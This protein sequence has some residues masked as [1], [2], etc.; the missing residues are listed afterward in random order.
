M[1]ARCR[2]QREQP[3]LGLFQQARIGIGLGGQL[4]EKGFRLGQRLLRAFQGDQRRRRRIGCIGLS[5]RDQALQRTRSS[6]QRRRRAMAPP[7]VRRQFGKCRGNRLRAPLALL[8]P[9]PLLRQPLLLALPR[10]QA[11]QFVDRVAQPFLVAFRRGDRLPRNLQRGERIAP[12]PPRRRRAVTQ[13]TRHAERV[14]QRGMARRVGQA[15]LLVLALHFHQQRAGPP[16]QCDANRLV[17][18]ECARPPVLRQ[19]A[20]QHHFVVRLQPLLDQQRGHRVTRRWREACGDTRLLR[21]GPHQCCVSA[22]AQRQAEAIQQD[23]LAGAGLSGQ[24]RQA[25]A[26]RQVKSLDQH[27]VANGQGAKHAAAPAA[28][29]GQ[30]IECQAREKNPRSSGVA[31][32]GC[33]TTPA[34]N[35]SL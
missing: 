4:A 34:S 18:D 30:K 19:H 22:R 7:I 9:L 23:R 27:H 14:E 26:E 3:L 12:P 1:L 29:F 16:Q 13:R 25:F 15:D 8:Q 28:A 11:G 35:R 20:A 17:V 2:T 33:G 21:T 10:R 32:P 31:G 5:G 24:H 6:A